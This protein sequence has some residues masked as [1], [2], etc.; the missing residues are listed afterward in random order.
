MSLGATFPR[1]SGPQTTALLE[2]LDQAT[3]YAHDRGTLVVAS[4]GNGDKQGRGIDHDHANYVTIPAQSAHVLGV[5][6]LGPVGFALGATNFDRLASYSNFGT[7]IVDFSGPGGDFVL[8][9]TDNCTL[10]INP[11]PPL[12]PSTTITNPCWAFDMVV[13]ACRG[14]TTRNVCFAAGTSM[15]APAVSAVAALI[16]GKRGS[17][18]PDALE[19]A[20]ASSA[21]DLG[22]PG[23]DAVYGKGRVNALRAVQ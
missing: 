15:S 4:A 21:D 5:S 17:M 3:T 1:S 13:S 22:D 23:V 2:A 7:S 14:T 19:T 9:G 8:P 12:S 16:V 20:L 18:N 10:D 6:A 11:A